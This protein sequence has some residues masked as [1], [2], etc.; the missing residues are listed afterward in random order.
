MPQSTHACVALFAIALLVP[1]DSCAFSLPLSNEA[2]RE[3]YF[4]G[5]RRDESTAR[6]LAKYKQHLAVPETGPYIASVELLTPFALE[7]LLSSERTMGYSAQQAE[8]NHRG[9]EEQMA[10]SIEVLLTDSYGPLLARATG[11]RSG[12]PIGY[13]LRS[14]DFWR[15]LEV[16]VTVDDKIVKPAHVQGEPTYLCSDGGCQLTGAIIRFEFPA[17]AFNSNSATVQVSPPEG[18]EV[19]VDFDLTAVR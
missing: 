16:Q 14:P 11:D 1:P 7:V 9:K 18:P 3:A 8:A 4:L 13:S 17:A 6:F 5:Q 19:T 15:D 12:S 10:M 2:I